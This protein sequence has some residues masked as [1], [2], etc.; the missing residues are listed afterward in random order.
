MR[1]SISCLVV[2]MGSSVCPSDLWSSVCNSH[3]RVPVCVFPCVCLY[4]YVC[5]SVLVSECN[6]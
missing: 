6:Q 3:A 1:R 5:V 4:V 2:E